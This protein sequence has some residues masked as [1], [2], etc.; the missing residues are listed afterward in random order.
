MLR[1]WLRDAAAAKRQVAPGAWG[2]AKRAP[3]RRRWGTLRF[4][5]GTQRAESGTRPDACIAGK[6]VLT[7][8]PQNWFNAPR[9]ERLPTDFVW[10]T[11]FSAAAL[12]G[13]AK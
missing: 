5:P 10:A 12:Q 7:H 2:K 3:V 11:G 1:A 8:C 4:A 9:L 6:L 13:I